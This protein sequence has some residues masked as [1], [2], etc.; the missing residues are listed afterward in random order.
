MPKKTPKTYDAPA[1][2]PHP[3]GRPANCVCD[4]REGQQHR[5]KCPAVAAPQVTMT[6]DK[7]SK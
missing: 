5:F 4:W 2:P 6:A 7:V 3:A 1:P